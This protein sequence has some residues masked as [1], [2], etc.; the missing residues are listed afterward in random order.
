MVDFIIQYFYKSITRLKDTRKSEN[1]FTLIE[2]TTVIALTGI[3]VP[4]ITGI[5]Y[6]SVNAQD[7]ALSITNGQLATST[8][9][10]AIQN[11]IERA[12][13]VE[14]NPVGHTN[15]YNNGNYL[16]LRTSDGTC[17]A[18]TVVGGKALR[19]KYTSNRGPTAV[20][21]QNFQEFTKVSATSGENAFEVINGD[22]VRYKFTVQHGSTKRE[23]SGTISP[24]VAQ[25][26]GSC[27]R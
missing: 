27:T 4:I 12:T 22:T 23:T 16:A 24:K 6:T 26:S 17:V 7:T 18:W 21:A 15:N 8:I 25:N 19:G 2:M 10:D 9:D 5:M 11:D 20:S 14:Y 1:G 13:W 3:L